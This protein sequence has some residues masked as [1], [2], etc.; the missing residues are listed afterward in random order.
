MNVKRG[1]QRIAWVSVALAAPIVWWAVYQS[2]SH[3]V[4]YRPELITLDFPEVD[5]PGL[6]AVFVEDT[7]I[8]YF[9]IHTSEAQMQERV[10]AVLKSAASIQPEGAQS[11]KSVREFAAAVRAK[12][13]E[14][15]DLSDLDLT[16]R[17][18]TK[19]PTYRGDV[20]LRE[21]EVESIYEKRPWWAS[22]V[23][24][25]VTGVWAGLLFGGIAAASWVARGFQDSGG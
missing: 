24:L 2:S 18:V 4:G 19:F 8:F 20:D 15:S 16:K 25:L 11:R 21:F 1:F 3:Q 23:A 7:G 5:H 12:Y 22:G 10:D 13:P 9:P 14:Y 17:I 6:R